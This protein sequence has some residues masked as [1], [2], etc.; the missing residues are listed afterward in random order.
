MVKYELEFIKD[1]T[2]FCK[3]FCF[4]NTYV[5]TQS[6]EGEKSYY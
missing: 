5:C 1:L 3:A 2:Q 6:F 4:A